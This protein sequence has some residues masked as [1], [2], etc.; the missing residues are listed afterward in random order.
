MSFAKQIKTE[1][2][3]LGLTQAQAATLC[4]VSPRVWW[5][6][7]NREGEPLY[8]TMRGVLDMLAESKLIP[9]S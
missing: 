4:R 8:P 7:E 9:R 2:E 5:K 6:W 3:R 1:R